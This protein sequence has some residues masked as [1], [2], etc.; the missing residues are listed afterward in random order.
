[1]S[2]PV[3]LASLPEWLRN[4]IASAHAGDIAV[5]AGHYAIF[6][7]GATPV[8]LLDDDAASPQG[9]AE[10]IAFT[11]RTWHA[12]CDAVALEPARRASL[13]VLVD[14]IQFVR[15]T[16]ED[17]AAAERLGAALATNYLDRVRTLPESHARALR[18]RSLGSADILRHDDDRW[19]F[20]ERELRVAAVEHLRERLHAAGGAGALLTANADESRI[21]VA[22]PGQAEYCLVHSGRTNCAGGY[23]ELLSEVYRRGIR[24]LIALVPMRCLGPVTVGTALAHRLYPLDALSIVTVAVPDIS[25]GAHAAVV[26]ESGQ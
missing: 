24:T 8:D 13:L 18:D 4:E 2:A 26:R 22:V 7:S 12:A 19:V 14:D 9:A 15:P 20:S 10:M 17:R 25:T 11:K 21:D 5:L 16:L 1:M 23:L 6:S 3:P